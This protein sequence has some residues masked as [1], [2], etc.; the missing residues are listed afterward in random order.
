MIGSPPKYMTH[1]RSKSDATQEAFDE[2][3]QALCDLLTIYDPCCADPTCEE[4][5]PLRPFRAVA[6]KYW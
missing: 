4:C 2:V 1:A 6:E 5:A 3:L